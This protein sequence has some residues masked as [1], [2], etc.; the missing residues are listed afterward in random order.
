M[1][2]SISSSQGLGAYLASRDNLTPQ[3]LIAKAFAG[4]ESCA[5]LVCGLPDFVIDLVATTDTSDGE[6]VDLTDQGV[7]FA[8][9]TIRKIRGRSYC[10]SPNDHYWYDWEE[11]VLGGT[12]PVLM[13]QRILGGGADQSGTV[14]EYG[15][16]LKFVAT[17]TALT[18]IDT[19][20]ASKGYAMGDITSGLAALT[21]PRN[22]VFLPKG[23]VLTG[24]SAITATA[25][26][27]NLVTFDV[28]NLDGL[29]TG[30]GGVVFYTE[31][32]TATG[33]VAGSPALG[34]VVAL[35][36]AVYPP[37]NHRLVMD[38]NN[39]TVKATATNANVADDSLRHRVEIWVDKAQPLQ[40]T[41]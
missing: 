20:L 35:A 33:S 23:G 11:D 13:G 36:F 4:N 37:I 24:P 41:T 30:T 6:A 10:S 40:H 39:V 12:T 14:F 18:T 9:D 8:A 28:T 34:G 21:V 31:D 2:I 7:T 29:G 26:A 16:D 32:S 17:I 3:E 1:A 15:E 38:S 25:A 22:R 27:G 19:I 5:R